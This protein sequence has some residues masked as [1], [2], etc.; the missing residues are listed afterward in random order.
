MG[1]AIESTQKLYPGLLERRPN[2]LFM[3]RC[4]QFIEMV[5]GTDSEVRAGMRS[6]RSHSSS[7]SSS[8]LHNVKPCS[9]PKGRPNSASP[10]PP[11]ASA[12]SSVVES[13]NA[14]NSA[15]SNGV[16]CDAN[17]LKID[18][19]E[20]EMDTSD[21]VSNGLS[22]SPPPPPLAAASNGYCSNG[23]AEPSNH[24]QDMGM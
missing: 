4:R 6:P 12:H 10:P 13:N 1:E 11:P 23:A 5:N 20:V 17:G 19:I 24:D 14:T 15:M 18:S 21:S 3:L 8:P 7:R 22:A 2:L 9:P 16:T